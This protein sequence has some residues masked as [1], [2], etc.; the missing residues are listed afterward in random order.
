MKQWNIFKSNL[1]TFNGKFR[2]I[3]N[4]KL[5]RKRFL[6]TDGDSWNYTCN[7]VTFYYASSKETES[8]SSQ[9]NRC[10]TDNTAD[11]THGI[12]SQN[13]SITLSYSRNY[14]LKFAD[15]KCSLGDV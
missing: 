10:I 6:I 4:V 12:A 5:Q 7:H 15:A 3:I 14:S 1:S 8:Q 9:V 11:I 13:N 2:V